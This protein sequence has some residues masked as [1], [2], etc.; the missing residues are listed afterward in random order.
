MEAQ[1]RQPVLDHLASSEAR[2][3]EVVKGLSSE[4]WSFRE[5]PERC[6]TLRQTR[7]SKSNF[8]L[9]RKPGVIPADGSVSH[10]N[11]RRQL[12]I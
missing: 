2:L 7:I 9:R 12:F 3:L 6:S 1:E 10:C 11:C 5:A 4:Q 8:R